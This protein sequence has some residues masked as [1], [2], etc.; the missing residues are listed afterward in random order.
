MAGVT[1]ADQPPVVGMAEIGQMLGVSRGRITVLIGR[2]DFP[3]PIAVLTMG[4]VWAHDQVS[5]WML[6]SGRTVH[7][8]PHIVL[9]SKGAV[10][11]RGA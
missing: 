7:D 1:A 4:R 10:A 11:G 3:A 8:I 5:A 9:P 2:A 6:A